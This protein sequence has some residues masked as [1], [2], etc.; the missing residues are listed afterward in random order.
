MA[1]RDDNRPATLHPIQYCTS[2][3]KHGKESAAAVSDYTTRASGIG[4]IAVYEVTGISNASL[5]HPV[6]A[7]GDF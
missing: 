7:I 5:V 2:F 4:N 6:D 3:F 1:L